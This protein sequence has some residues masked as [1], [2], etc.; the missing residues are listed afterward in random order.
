MGTDFNMISLGLETATHDRSRSIFPLRSIW[1]TLRRRS[2][3]WLRSRGWLLALSE[4]RSCYQR[5][6]LGRRKQ[7]DTVGLVFAQVLASMPPLTFPHSCS[8]TL[9]YTLSIRALERERPYLT[10]TDYE[11]FAQAWFQAAK[12]YSRSADSGCD[13]QA[14]DSLNNS[15][16][17]SHSP[18]VVSQ[19]SF[20]SCGHAKRLVDAHEIVPSKIEGYRS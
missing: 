19:P 1:Q 10:L 11:L 7:L 12:W 8:E 14:V 15:E 9:A 3:S 16:K 13:R 18:H 4:L 20:H 6:L 2:L 17:F 5:I